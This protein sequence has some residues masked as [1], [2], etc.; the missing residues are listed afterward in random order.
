MEI[1]TLL[2]ANIRKKKGTFISVMLMTAIVVTVITAVFSVR[3]N[4]DNALDRAFEYAG[5]GEISTALPTDLLT[6]ELRS[7]VE[8]SKLVESVG[9]S[10]ALVIYGIII[11]DFHDRN[12]SLLMELTDGIRLYRSDESG[13]EDEIPA[14]K[15]GE[16]YLPLGLKYKLQCNVGDTVKF[17]FAYDNSLEFTVKGFVQEPSVGSMMIGSKYIFISHEDFEDAYAKLKPLESEYAYLDYTL[18]R[19][20]QAADSN[21]SPAKFQR[22]LNLET[23]IVDF[24]DFSF[25][26]DQSLRY[27]TLLPDI[28]L[29]VV[30]AFSIFLFVIVL[31]V[32]SHS[33]G[34]EIEI[35]Y[36]TFGVLKSQGFFKGKIRAVILLQYFLAEVIGIIVGCFAAIPIEKVISGVFKYVTAVMPDNVISVG[37]ALMFVL[38][39]LFVS[40]VLIFIKTKKIARI[41]PVRAI[42]GGREEIFFDSR[43]NMPVTKKCLSAS[44]SFRQ[45]TSAKRRYFGT[46]LITAILTFCMITI[47]LLGNTFSSRYAMSAIGV[48][49]YDISVAFLDSDNAGKL[50]EI[51]DIITSHTEIEQKNSMVW[52]YLSLNGENLQCTIYEY[53]EYTCVIKGRAPLYDNEILITEMVADTLELQMGDEVTVTSQGKEER[54]IISGIFQSISDSG[55]VFSMNFDGAQRLDIGTN[56]SYRSYVIADKSYAETIANEISEKYGDDISITVY[57]DE[58]QYPELELYDMI[59]LIL[60]VVIYAFSIIFAFI[61]VRMVCAKMFIQERTDIGIYKAIGFTSKRLRVGFAIRFL[62]VAVIGSV[63]GIILSIFLSSRILTLLF[64]LIGISRMVLEYTAI[65]LLVPVATISLSFFVFAY[66]V[67]RKVRKVA[68]RE[69]VVE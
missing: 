25:T 65:S 63:L 23:K 41:S 50:D 49:L 69:L 39:I 20:H 15:N 59:I 4:Y 21:L 56:T 43:L 9:Y 5:C 19:I 29:D 54:F 53:P 38:V 51:D 32:M 60:K 13:F 52:Q 12:Q 68:V 27:S 34:T 57:V 14:L 24:S 33:I 55:M 35:D 47:N 22:Q 42:S 30:L 18:V 7:S 64:S 10:R 37:K 6:D 40:A 26:K 8:N 58:E 45:F 1:L 17:D 48:T 36:T 31:I 46:I 3:D 2:K 67:S 61:V 44:L 16:V 66:L 28:I 62:I 11:G